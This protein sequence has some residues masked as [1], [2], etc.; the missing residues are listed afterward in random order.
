[1]DDVT[2]LPNH[3]YSFVYNYKYYIG[4]FKKVLEKHDKQMYIF[5]NFSI[6]SNLNEPSYIF[7]FQHYKL[8]PNI[9]K[10]LS[11]NTFSDSDSDGFESDISPNYKNILE[12]QIRDDFD[13]YIKIDLCDIKK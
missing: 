5:N 1:M 3:K 13:D 10:L 4:F 7:D 6:E 2:F 8:S 12:G 9:A 11:H